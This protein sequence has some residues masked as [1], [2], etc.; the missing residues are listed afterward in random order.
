MYVSGE[1]GDYPHA[2]GV[3]LA[4][5]DK[6]ATWASHPVSLLANELAPHRIRVNSVNPTN[7]AT[8]MILDP[9][10]YRFFRPDLDN[11]SKEDATAAF[12]SYLLLDQPWVEAEEVSNAVLWL[13]SE[14]ARSIT[15]V[16]LPID[17]GT[18]VKWPGT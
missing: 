8:P 14:E 1:R 9:A 3:L 17:A 10:V 11:P 7:V 2:Q 16:Q 5:D 6:G 12:G 13:C 4:S 15:G 18:L